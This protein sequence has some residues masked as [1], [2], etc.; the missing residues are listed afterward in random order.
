MLTYIR[1]RSEKNRFNT[2][3]LKTFGKLNDREIKSIDGKLERLFVELMMHYD[4]D[5]ETTRDR[6]RQFRLKLIGSKAD[7]S[8]HREGVAR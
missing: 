7:T 1:E 8:R 6:V 4:W 3:L 5:N 2:Q